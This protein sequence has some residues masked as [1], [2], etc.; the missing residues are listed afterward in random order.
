MNAVIAMCT[1]CEIH[2]PKVIFS[3]Q[4]YRTFDDKEKINKRQHFYGPKEL[5]NQTNNDNDNN[6]SK[7]SM[8]I[9]NCDGC[10][11]FGIIKYL[12]NEHES[13]TSFLSS[14]QPLAEDIANLLSHACIRFKIFPIIIIKL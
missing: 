9:K 7:T 4:S 13:R 14:R 5:I 1:F 12:S 6:N 8:T 11:N 2:G 3:T 10:E